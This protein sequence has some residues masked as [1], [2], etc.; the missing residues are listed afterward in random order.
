M[1]Q[2]LA[3][4]QNIRQNRPSKIT[5]PHWHHQLCHLQLQVRTQAQKISRNHLLCHHRCPWPWIKNICRYNCFDNNSRREQVLPSQPE[6]LLITRL[7]QTQSTVVTIYQWRSLMWKCNN[8]DWLPTQM[9]N[10]LSHLP[11]NFCRHNLGLGPQ[12]ILRKARLIRS[13]QKAGLP[14]KASSAIIKMRKV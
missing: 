7:M 3:K 8:Q 4:L 9:C 5:D 13:S 10:W 14:M 12:S 11:R 1:D 6:R 2:Y